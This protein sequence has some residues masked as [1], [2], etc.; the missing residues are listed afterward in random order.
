MALTSYLNW[1]S[2]LQADLNLGASFFNEATPE[3]EVLVA[4]DYYYN[5]NNN[6]HLFLPN[7]CNSLDPNTSYLDPY[8]NLLYPHE[9]VP[10]DPFMYENHY[11]S[12]L[13][14]PKRQKCLPYDQNLTMMDLI[15]PT[16]NSFFGGNNIVVPKVPEFYY[17]EVAMLGNGE[18]TVA[19][20]VVEEERKKNENT[21]PPRP[22]VS[23][24]SVAARERRRKIT[25]K[26]QD[27]GKLVPGGSKMNTADMLHAA[28]KYVNYLQAQ[29]AMLQLM[30]PLKEDNKVFA[31][32]EEMQKLLTCPVVEE[33]M[34]ME[35]KCFVPKEFVTNLTN[36]KDI[37]SLPS[38]LKDLNQFI[39]TDTD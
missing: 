34:Y 20:A 32:T 19:A 17:D 30:N 21:L 15:A 23:A 29:V 10:Y 12:L 9:L 39:S 24:Q 14:C 33:K 31:A 16:N 35:E 18:S 4:P 3:E 8:S 2:N 13:P 27:L 28:A 5:H 26:T 38:I 11:D 36:H 7:C 6:H 1:E 22:V 25:E 37:Q